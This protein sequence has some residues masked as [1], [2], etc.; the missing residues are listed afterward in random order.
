MFWVEALNAEC[1][2]HHLRQMEG[3]ALRLSSHP[4]PGRLILSFREIGPGVAPAARRGGDDGV[5]T[6]S[7]GCTVAS[8]L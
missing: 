1:I 4:C 3:Q 6:S 2:V 8:S 7:R 5:Y